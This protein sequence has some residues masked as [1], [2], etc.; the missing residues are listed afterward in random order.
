MPVDAV[1]EDEIF[2]E[3]YLVVGV[4]TATQS[5]NGTILTDVWQ[6]T[7]DVTLAT[8]VQTDLISSCYRLQM[9]IEITAIWSHS[10]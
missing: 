1:S 2:R 10:N 3:R 4:L 8:A 6:A 5:A 7:A 9:Y